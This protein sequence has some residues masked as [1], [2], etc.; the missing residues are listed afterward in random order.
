MVNEIINSIPSSLITNVAQINSVIWTLTPHGVFS[1]S[2]PGILILK[3][4]GGSQCVSNIR[5]PGRP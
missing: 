5:C 2:Q 3:S 4:C 1:A